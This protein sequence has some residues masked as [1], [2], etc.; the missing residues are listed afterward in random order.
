MALISCPECGKMISDKAKF[1]PSCGYPID[2]QP[3][4]QLDFCKVPQEVEEEFSADDLYL[5]GISYY[6]GENGIDMN[7]D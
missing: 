1:C 6:F 5:L 7:Q 2:T 3:V 4:T